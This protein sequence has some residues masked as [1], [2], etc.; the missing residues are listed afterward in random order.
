MRGL[1]VGNRG[2]FWLGQIAQILF[3]V[4]KAPMEALEAYT[5]YGVTIGGDS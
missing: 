4:V 2:L 1:I 3:A 5:V